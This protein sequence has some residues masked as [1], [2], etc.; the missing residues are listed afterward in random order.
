MLYDAAQA[1]LE[2][3]PEEALTAQ[4]EVVGVQLLKL[5]QRAA[6]PSAR[7]GALWAL[8]RTKAREFYS[9]NALKLGLGG[10]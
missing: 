1:Q 9:W 3:S 2:F 5:A 10:R 4:G 8:R 7:W 6:T